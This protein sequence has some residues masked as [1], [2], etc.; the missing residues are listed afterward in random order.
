MK[1]CCKLLSDF[2]EDKRIDVQYDEILREYFIHVHY[3]GTARQLLLFCPWCGSKLPKN[4]RDEY[5]DIL[6]EIFGEDA[7]LDEV[8]LPE[9]FKNSA[10]WEKREL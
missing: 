7:E 6:R 1:H 5:Y 9:E 2:I 8:N 10:W 3:G 4:L